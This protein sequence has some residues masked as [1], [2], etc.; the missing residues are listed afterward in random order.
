M[1]AGYVKRSGTFV[2]NK[3]ESIHRWYSYLEGYSYCL[4]EDIIDEIGAENIKN[5][6]DPFCGTGTTVLVASSKGIKSCY[7][8]S[9]PFMQ[10]VIEAKINAVKR[11]REN[12][13][14]SHNLEKFIIAINNR[15]QYILDNKSEYEWE[16]F[17][18]YFDENVLCQIRYLY[19][20]TSIIDDND[21]RLIA[22][23]L[24]AS[25]IVRSSNMVRQ[26][27]L[28]FAKEKEKKQSDKEVLH[29][30]ISKLEEAIK[31]IE[32]NDCPTL[33]ETIKLA[34][35]ARNIEIVNDVDCVITSP[36]YLNGTNYIRNTK[37]ELKLLEFISSESELPLFHSKGIIAGINNVSKRNADIP[38]LDVIKPYVNM[39]EPVAYD[40][41]IT[42]MVAGYF[43]DMDNVINKLSIALKDNG[44]FI[45][46]IGDSQFAGIHIPT[47]EILKC[48]CYSHGFNIFDENILRERRSK[49]GMILSQRLLK[50]KL[51]K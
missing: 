21:S 7:T 9:N 8:E 15:Q 50:F 45:M 33:S 47:H 27:D 34:D 20:Y 10:C 4:I 35:D 40:K 49:N 23:V 17:E 5:I 3:N 37:L 16:G 36:P 2:L 46:D 32:S 18:K 43:Y 48:I 39:L 41:R 51:R 24:L 28:R 44:Y 12:N 14:K 42:K 26:G 29:N 30:Y 38:I 1:S 25:I 22:K 6:Y 31:D 19:R 11:L 13:I